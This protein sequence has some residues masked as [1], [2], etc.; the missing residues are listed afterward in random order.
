MLPMIILGVSAMLS[1]WMSMVIRDGGL[2][3]HC[4]RLER[5]M[6]G[7]VRN[8]RPKA[9]Q[10]TKGAKD[11]AGDKSE[12]QH[13][14]NSLTTLRCGHRKLG[15]HVHGT[16]GANSRGTKRACAP[17]QGLSR[18]LLSDSFHFSNLVTV[19]YERLL[20]RLPTGWFTTKGRT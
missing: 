5:P 4:G 18:D 1:E 8:S 20:H 3:T 10:K 12:P 14:C 17:Q 13:R 19:A 16:A 11:H 15:S 7:I 6:L 9:W 2:D